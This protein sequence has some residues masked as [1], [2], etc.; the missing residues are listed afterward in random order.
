MERRAV[1]HPPVDGRKLRSDHE[2]AIYQRVAPDHA[3][4]RSEARE[5]GK[6]IGA[7]RRS[8]ARHYILCFEPHPVRHWHAVLRHRRTACN[9]ALTC[10]TVSGGSRPGSRRLDA[11]RRKVRAPKGR[12]PGNAW[13]A[14]AHGKCHRKQTASNP[15]GREVRVKRCG[16]SAPR[17]WQ[18]RWQG[19]PHPEQDQIGERVANRRRGVAR[20]AP[21]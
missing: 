10:H 9:T 3:K 16:K 5:S 11:G 21:G 1:A 4:G 19:K 15:R 2:C 12:V 7:V 8:D 20:A 6:R 18:H 17:R 13:G 14:R